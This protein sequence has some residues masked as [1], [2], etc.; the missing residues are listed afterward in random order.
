MPTTRAASRS[1]RRASTRG[2]CGDRSGMSVD[3]QPPSSARRGTRR[4]RVSRPLPEEAS[5]TS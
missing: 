1:G 4:K 3:S 5:R 2:P